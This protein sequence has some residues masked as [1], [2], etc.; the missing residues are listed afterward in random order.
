[1]LIIVRNFEGW[2]HRGVQLTL[3]EWNW[4]LLPGF[5]KTLV[6]L[7]L[8]SHPEK[9]LLPRSDEPAAVRMGKRRDR[10][11]PTGPDSRTQSEQPVQGARTI[12]AATHSRIS[13]FFFFVFLFLPIVSLLVYRLIYPP[14]YPGTDTNTNTLRSVYERGLVRAEDVSYREILAVSD[15]IPFSRV[16]DFPLLIFEDNEMLFCLFGSLSF[17]F[18]SFFFFLICFPSNSGKFQGFGKYVSKA[19]HVSGTGI[20][21]SMVRHLRAFLV[22]P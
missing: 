16:L 13:I 20:R 3:P 2:L 17:F 7:I 10:R 18:L 6:F 9:T 1:M 11:V 12:D 15:R 8:L 21:N 19:L 5:R 4:T 22:S 14:P